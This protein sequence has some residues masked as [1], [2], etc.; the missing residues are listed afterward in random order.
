MYK[1][2]GGGKCGLLEGVL[3]HICL[4]SLKTKPHKIYVRTVHGSAKIEIGG[5][6]GKLSK[7]K[8]SEYYHYTTLL[9]THLIFC[10]SM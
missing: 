8:S 4:E 9:S 2:L 7:C 6:G 5:G 10:V 3:F 1:D